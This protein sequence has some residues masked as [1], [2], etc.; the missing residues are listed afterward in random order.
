M[1]MSIS[2][3]HHYIPQFLIR[4]FTDDR[5]F[6]HVYDKETDEIVQRSPKMAFYE[7]N[8]NTFTV[9]EKEVDHLEKLYSDLDQDFAANLAEVLSDSES[10]AGSLANLLLL[11]MTLKWRTP[12]SDEE[13]NR[14]KQDMTMADLG[15]RI[16]LKDP[17][18][19]VEPKALQRLLDSDLFKEGKRTL[20]PIQP[21]LNADKTLNEAKLIELHEN[22]YLHRLADK[23]YPAILGDCGIIE[24]SRVAYDQ[25]GNFV[26]PL[27]STV[28]LICKKNTRAHVGDIARFYS[29][30]DLTTLF[31]AKRYVGCANKEHLQSLIA[32]YH[33]GR[34]RP[35]TEEYLMNALFEGI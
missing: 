20:L 12:A 35:G 14:L 18:Q 8:R 11:A 3:R 22:S 34:S 15:I 21:F 31:S 26:F 32:V 6:L 17:T 13:F 25:L 19:K 27:S 24:Q 7:W 33:M 4:H 28:T 29:C 1:I 5:G 16:I 9:G 30:R 2:R 23:R 10:D